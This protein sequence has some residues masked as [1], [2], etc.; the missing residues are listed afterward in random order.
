MNHPPV[1]TSSRFLQHLSLFWWM[2]VRTY[3]LSFSFFPSF[4]L[5]LFF[6]FLEKTISV[7]VDGWRDNLSSAF[8]NS[9]ALLA[10]RHKSTPAAASPHPPGS[11]FKGFPLLAPTKRTGLGLWSA[12]LGAPHPSLVTTW[13]P[14]RTGGPAWQVP[15]ASATSVEETRV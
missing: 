1:R 9:K 7:V 14:S 3:C 13:S 10:S 4:F 2:E 11:G 6:Y 12:P 5:F 15:S 8:I